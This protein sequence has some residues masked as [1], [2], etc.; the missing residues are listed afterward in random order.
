MSALLA[1]NKTTGLAN[2]AADLAAKPV[3]SSAGMCRVSYSELG[4]DLL[5]NNAFRKD[6]DLSSVARNLINRQKFLI[7]PESSSEKVEL[8]KVG[9]AFGTIGGQAFVIAVFTA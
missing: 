5:V 8:S 1:E 3:I 9:F 6:A 2:C 7:L 4:S